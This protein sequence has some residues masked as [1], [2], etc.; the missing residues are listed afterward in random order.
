MFHT[1]L[2][3]TLPYIMKLM[4]SQEEKMLV[5]FVLV[6]GE[7][8][9]SVIQYI[10]YYFQSRKIE[11]ILLGFILVISIIYYLCPLLENNVH[12]NRFTSFHTSVHV[13]H[14]CEFKYTSY[15]YILLGKQ[16]D[17]P[18]KCR[19][20]IKFKYIFRSLFLISYAL[21]VLKALIIYFYYQQSLI[22]YFLMSSFHI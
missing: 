16:K 19:S 13:R 20:P 14:R 9:K 10:L 6:F 7:K 1:M 21:E 4:K 12:E 22:I 3:N 15:R 8:Y 2:I 11:L 5:K 18:Q 17:F